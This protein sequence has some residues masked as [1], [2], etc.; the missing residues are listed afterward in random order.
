[1]YRW[2]ICERI[3]NSIRLAVLLLRMYVVRCIH[4]SHILQN[5]RD[6]CARAIILDILGHILWPLRTFD[7]TMTLACSSTREC[8]PRCRRRR[9]RWRRRA[10]AALAARLLRVHSAHACGKN[11]LHLLQSSTL[12]CCDV[13]IVNGKVMLDKTFVLLQELLL[14]H[15]LRVHVLAENSLLLQELDECSASTLIKSMAAG[16]LEPV[17]VLGALEVIA[18]QR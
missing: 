18:V 8:L 12:C 9:W 17:P 14:K 2:R 5:P 1:M 15:I 16:L 13:R 6:I 3:V 11:A 7:F 10:L 4:V